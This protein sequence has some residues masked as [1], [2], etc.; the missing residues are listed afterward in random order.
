R[1]L[2]GI[3]NDAGIAGVSASYTNV[4]DPTSTNSVLSIANTSGA[5]VTIAEAGASG[6]TAGGDLAALAS[7]DVTTDA[8]ASSALTSIETLIQTGI[9]AEASFGS[10][11]NRINI[12]KEFVTDLT[13]AL[14]SGIGAL[15]DADIE[16]A[17][18]RLQAL[19]VQQQLGIQALSIANQAPQVLLSLFR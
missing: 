16:S 5:A 12:Q 1:H 7:V 3:I 14:K 6:G 13:D 8:G 4:A 9:D 17:S 18:A 15:T 19:Q 2:A 10:T 11:G